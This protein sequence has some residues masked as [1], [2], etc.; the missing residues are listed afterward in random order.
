MVEDTSLCF[1]AYKGL[2]GAAQHAAAATTAQ[3]LLNFQQQASC[4]NLT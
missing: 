4:L 2:P 3:Q 1:N